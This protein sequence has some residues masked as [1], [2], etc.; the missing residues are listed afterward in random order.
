M[1]LQPSMSLTKAEQ[2]EA[3][4]G[5]ERLDQAHGDNVLK[6]QNS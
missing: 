1:H 6:P 3:L 2:V 4:N 5:A